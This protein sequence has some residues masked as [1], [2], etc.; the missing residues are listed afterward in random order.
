MSIEELIK[1]IPEIIIYFVP[2][3]VFLG[4]FC[5]LTSK[6]IKEI[7]NLFV[8]SVVISYLFVVIANLICAVARIDL[9]YSIYFSLLLSIV[10]SFLCVKVYF[11]N[12]Y[13]KVFCKIANTSG[14]SSIW[15]DLID[16]T[17]GANIRGFIKYQNHDAE[18]KGTVRYYEILDNGDC[19]IALW[20]YTITGEDFVLH[21]KDDYNKLFYINSSAIH[22]LEVFKGK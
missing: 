7:E 13:K 1:I 3:Y 2:G 20:N 11:S 19:N 5:F 6:K 4:I 22:G 12:A 8:R 15:E 18:I 21:P 14:H 16:R 10:L 9:I 17:K